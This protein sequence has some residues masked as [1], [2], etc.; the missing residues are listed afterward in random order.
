MLLEKAMHWKARWRYC[1]SMLED[2]GRRLGHVEEQRV[3]EESLREGFAPFASERLLVCKYDSELMIGAVPLLVRM[4]TDVLLCS[5]RK[6]PTP[7]CL[8]S[9]ACCSNG[10]NPQTLPSMTVVF[11]QAGLSCSDDRGTRFLA[12]SSL[13]AHV[14]LIRTRKS[15]VIQRGGRGEPMFSEQAANLPSVHKNRHLPLSPRTTLLNISYEASPALSRCRD[16]G[17][18]DRGRRLHV[19]EGSASVESSCRVASM[20][21]FGFCNRTFRKTHASSL[22]DVIG[23]TCPCCEM[24]CNACVRSSRRFRICFII[25]NRIMVPQ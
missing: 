4:R 11:F 5:V 13:D 22:L 12:S 1:G 20:L 19:F 8:C 16:M 17:H 25:W 18:V 9:S 24:L 10:F 6:N 7:Y 2:L 14:D 3:D 15:A 23:S 21:R